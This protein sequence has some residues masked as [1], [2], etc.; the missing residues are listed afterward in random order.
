[1]GAGEA[2]K[3]ILGGSEHGALGSDKAI[4]AIMK[5]SERDD[6]SE[7]RAAVFADHFGP[8]LDDFGMSIEEMI[9]LLNPESF[10]HLLGCILED[11]MSCNFEPDE[12]NVVDDYLKRRGWKESEPTKACLRALQR[13]V[14]SAYEVVDTAPGSHVLAA[15]SDS[16]R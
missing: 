10:M 4:G 5:W 1:M 6:W 11:F 16:R 9:D 13:S 8:V 3:A 12:R 15:R 14:M 7:R 2:K